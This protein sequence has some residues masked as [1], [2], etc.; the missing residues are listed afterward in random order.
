MDPCDQPRPQVQRQT[1]LASNTIQTSNGLSLMLFRRC[2]ST[3]RDHIAFETRFDRFT[4]SNLV[5]PSLFVAL[6]TSHV[7]CLHPQSNE[8][9]GSPHS[10]INSFFPPRLHFTFSSPRHQKPPLRQE[11]SRSRSSL[12]ASAFAHH[13]TSSFWPSPK[14]KPLTA[15]AFAIH[16]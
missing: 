10:R 9:L 12:S 6:S 16:T 1:L 8:L 14:P 11:P 2:S 4:S 3:T 15:S 7:F 5:A 13:K